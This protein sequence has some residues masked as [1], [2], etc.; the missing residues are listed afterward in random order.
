LTATYEVLVVDDDQEVL[1][2]LAQLLPNKVGE[3]DIRWQFC[4]GFDEALTLL[5][6]RRFDI[7]LSDIYRN[8]EQGR[9]NIEQGDVRARELVD[10][11]RANRFCPIILFTDGQLPPELLHRPFVWA[12]DKGTP[13]FQVKLSELITAA[14]S[15]GLPGIARRLHDE[16]DRYAGSY[17]WTFLAE[18]W[19][20]LQDR[21]G[22][23]A[24]T[25]ERIIRRRAAVQL[26]RVDRAAESVAAR[27]SVDPFDYYIYPPISESIRLGEII[28][29]KSTSEFRVVLTPHCFLVMQPG[30]DAPRATHVLTAL[31]IPAEEFRANWKWESKE[32]GIADQLRRRTSFPAE[33]VGVN[34]PQGRYCYLPGFLEIPDLYCDLMQLESIGYKTVSD[35]FE[36]VAVLDW[37]FAE[38]LQATMDI[39]YGSVGVP[40]LGPDSI[41]HLRPPPKK[42]PKKA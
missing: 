8:R 21:H 17:V 38:A 1:N 4:A 25:L 29:R 42:A 9:K 15:T 3:D 35:D 26:A 36:R 41:S 13:D 40:G 7:L 6:I 2:Q 28:R 20:I 24:L 37:P 10:E 33:R 14:I 12:T 32:A 5:K 19:D 31:A 22:L 18:R 16:L 30:Q 23:D 34:A 11:I 27:T 39:L